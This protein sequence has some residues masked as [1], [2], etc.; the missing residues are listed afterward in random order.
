MTVLRSLLL[1]T[2]VLGLA[3]ACGS[4][5]G[6]SSTSSGTDAAAATP[7]PGD[8]ASLSDESELLLG[9]LR[10][11]G[12]ELAVTPDQAVTLTFL[13]EAVQS[14]AESDTTAEAEMSALIGQIRSAMTAAQLQGIDAMQLTEGDLRTAMQDIGP[15]QSTPAA[16][17]S[18]GSGRE[19]PFAG[20]PPAGGEFSGAP[21]GAGLGPQAGESLSQEQIATLQ[22]QRET[23]AGAGSRAALRLIRPVIELL[24]QRSQEG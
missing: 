18:D 17:S 23:G 5:A 4:S 11:E 6:T 20:G 3:A 7:V 9:T 19:F 15:V 16:G 21:P 10:L 2:L 22:A 14:L 8:A 1:S 24:T 12:T 13:W